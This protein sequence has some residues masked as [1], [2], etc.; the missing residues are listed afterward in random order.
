MGWTIKF[1]FH[2]NLT[3]H[4]HIA[5]VYPKTDTTHT[6]IPEFSLSDSN[7][8]KCAH[9]SHFC[10]SYRLPNKPKNYLRCRWRREYSFILKGRSSKK[11]SKVH[12]RWVDSTDDVKTMD[13]S[14][15]KLC[16]S[17]TKYNGLYFVSQNCTGHMKIES[18]LKQQ[19]EQHELCWELLRILL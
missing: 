18:V 8:I 2:N 11:F 15:P 12:R 6:H 3:Q 16:S 5:C 10:L 17:A 4:C 7:Q 9:M 19:W 13:F 1:A 14:S